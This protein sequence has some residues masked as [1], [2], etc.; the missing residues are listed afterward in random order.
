MGTAD[1]RLLELTMLV[2]PARSSTFASPVLPVQ[3]RFSLILSSMTDGCGGG[4][5]Y[6]FFESPV[7]YVRSQSLVQG[8]TKHAGAATHS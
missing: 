1:D 6:Q 5:L 2:A 7:S 3:F 8:R 4:L